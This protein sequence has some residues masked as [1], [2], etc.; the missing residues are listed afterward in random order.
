MLLE[1]RLEVT[2]KSVPESATRE[3]L[4]HNASD[5]SMDSDAFASMDG[6][7][8]VQNRMQ[9]RDKSVILYK[10]CS[11]SPEWGVPTG[12]KLFVLTFKATPFA[13]ACVYAVH[14]GTIKP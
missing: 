4:L 13:Y 2:K 12:V 9:L 8:K 3:D 14:N 5:P 1:E 11:S 10:T 7:V 6:N